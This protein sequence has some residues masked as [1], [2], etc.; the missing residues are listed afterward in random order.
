MTFLSLEHRSSGSPLYESNHETLKC[1]RDRENGFI[2]LK[3]LRQEMYSK[4]GEERWTRVF[5]EHQGDG[6][7]KRM[8]ESLCLHHHSVGASLDVEGFQWMVEDAA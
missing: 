3:G 8:P 1:V 4:S 7:R 5:A 2:R 6:I